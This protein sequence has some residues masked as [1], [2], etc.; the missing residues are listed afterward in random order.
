MPS[1]P[2]CI[3]ATGTLIAL[4]A[5]ISPRSVEEVISRLMDAFISIPSK[6]LAL[7]CPSLALA[8]RLPLLIITAVLGYAPGAFRD[9]AASLA[10]DQASLEYVYVAKTRGEGRLYIACRGL[11][12]YPQPGDGRFGPA[13]CVHWCCSSVD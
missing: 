9:C 1:L 4:L 6:M 13:V 7:V 3:S 10:L 12:D 2:R 5:V 8:V 11:R